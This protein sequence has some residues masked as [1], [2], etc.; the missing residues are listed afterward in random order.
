MYIPMFLIW[1]SF[2]KVAEPHIVPNLSPSP[3]PKLAYNSQK[4][5]NQYRFITD[6]HN[7]QELF[8]KMILGF[9]ISIPPLSGASTLDKQEALYDYWK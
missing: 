8:K 6:S 4:F 3:F 7:K 5:Q 9:Q 1:S 2:Q